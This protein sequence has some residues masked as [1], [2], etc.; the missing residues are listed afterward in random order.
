MFRN[1]SELVSNINS[2]DHIAPSFPKR[3]MLQF[4]FEKGAPILPKNNDRMINTVY[5]ICIEV[6]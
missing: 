2:F 4:L 5:R 1:L 6:N 3:E